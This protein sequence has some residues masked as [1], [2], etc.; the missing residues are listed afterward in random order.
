VHLTVF[1]IV[2]RTGK[3]RLTGTLNPA[4]SPANAIIHFL[5]WYPELPNKFTVIL[6]SERAGPSF[7]TDHSAPYTVFRIY[8]SLI[9]HSKAICLSVSR[10]RVT[11]CAANSLIGSAGTVICD[12][13]IFGKVTKTMSGAVQAAR[14]NACLSRDFPP[15][16]TARL[17]FHV[18]RL[19]QSLFSSPT[20][21]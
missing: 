14:L 12:Y 15:P 21:F 20:R 10:D 5:V 4:H 2:E 1:G 3:K 19:D 11:W 6:R 13:T 17:L 9:R 16:I 8:L 18:T 7:W